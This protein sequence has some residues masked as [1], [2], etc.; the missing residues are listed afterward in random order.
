MKDK[1]KQASKIP[2]TQTNTNR[3]KTTDGGAGPWGVKTAL[4]RKNDTT[5]IIAGALAVTL[6]VFFVFFFGSSRSGPETLST[7]PDDTR[8]QALETR[9]TDLEQSLAALEA[10]VNAVPRTNV[11]TELAEIRKQMATLESGFLI[12]LESLDR[13]TGRLE[14]APAAPP[15]P[16]VEDSAT[17]KV[18]TANP[19]IREKKALEKPPASGGASSDTAQTFHT[20][21]KGETLW[22]ISQKYGVTVD[23]LR[24]LNNLAPGADIY[25][26]TKI[27]VR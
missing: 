5:L 26:G 20:V 1:E 12:R 25:S 23:R 27:R 8:F 11:N 19:E 9:L 7:P 6:I 17:P 15:R 10:K 24:E 3:K 4:F 2:T 16:L 13:R 18:V 14:E 22:R 21:Q